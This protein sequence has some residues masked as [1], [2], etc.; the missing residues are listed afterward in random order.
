LKPR[1]EARAESCST[2]AARI[3]HTL[4]RKKARHD[5]ERAAPAA[6]VVNSVSLVLIVQSRRLIRLIYDMG[7]SSGS[8]LMLQTHRSAGFRVM[9][10][11]I[12]VFSTAK[13]TMPANRRQYSH[14]RKAPPSQRILMV[15]MSES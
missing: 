1:M 10:P 6:N 15:G 9:D 3:D 4:V 7:A 8:G 11:R 12:V 5:S 13:R 2:L 14:I